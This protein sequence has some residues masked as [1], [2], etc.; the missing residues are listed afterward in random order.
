MKRP[1]VIFLLSGAAALGA[2]SITLSSPRPTDDVVGSMVD[3]GRD[4]SPA[5]SG[6]MTAK[7]PEGNFGRPSAAQAKRLERELART[8]A[9]HAPSAAN[10]AER[11]R[12]DG[13]ISKV[14]PLEHL[15][16]S[17][18]RIGAGGAIERDCARGLGEASEF[19]L[20]VPNPTPAN[21]PEEM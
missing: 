12:T 8:L 11:F 4:L 19:L 6:A 3:E 15:S 7:D 10:T 1:A 5:L 18:A 17:V 21:T 20:S 14:L 9:P 13:A 16:F 2:A